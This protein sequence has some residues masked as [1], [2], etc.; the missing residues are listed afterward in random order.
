[1]LALHMRETPG[2]RNRCQVAKWRCEPN[3][4]VERFSRDLADV[5]IRISDWAHTMEHDGREESLAEINT[6]VL[7]WFD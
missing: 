2:A 1:M 4:T 6:L 3:F 5:L 7:S